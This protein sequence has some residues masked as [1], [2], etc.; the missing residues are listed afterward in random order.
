MVTTMSFSHQVFDPIRYLL[1]LVGV[2]IR[3][4]A[5]FMLSLCCLYA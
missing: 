4:V 5:F 1:D 2:P 3:M